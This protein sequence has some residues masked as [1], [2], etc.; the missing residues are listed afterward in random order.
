MKR[1][2]LR[3]SIQT[4]LE[5]VTFILVAFVCM[6]DDFELRFIPTLLAILVVIV[7]NTFVLNKYAKY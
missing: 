7:T 4:T 2:Y 6:I 3:K 5:I 1:R